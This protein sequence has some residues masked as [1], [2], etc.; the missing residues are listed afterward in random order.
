MFKGFKNG[1]HLLFTVSRK[2]FLFST[3][4]R[5]IRKNFFSTLSLLIIKFSVIIHIFWF[6]CP[7]PGLIPWVFLLM[8]R[9]SSPS[10][11]P[12]YS[13]LLMFLVDICPYRRKYFSINNITSKILK[14]F[15]LLKKVNKN[16]KVL[17]LKR[18]S[19]GSKFYYQ[20]LDLK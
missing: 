1:F 7:F 10:L 20:S 15:L 18:L 19:F 12:S 8:V 16:L 17:K 2:T 14:S 5:K 6:T 11:T 4:K 13:W 3:S 9:N